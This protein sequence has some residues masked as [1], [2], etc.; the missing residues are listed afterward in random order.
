MQMSWY[1]LS[2]LNTTFGTKD[3][4]KYAHG[5]DSSSTGLSGTKCWQDK[6]LCYQV[7]YERTVSKFPWTGIA[8]YII[9]YLLWGS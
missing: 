1:K 8:S 6:F 5:L 3:R 4:K 9:M 7:V 2:P